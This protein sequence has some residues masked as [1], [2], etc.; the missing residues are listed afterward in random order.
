ML[1]E[2]PLPPLVVTNPTTDAGRRLV[3]L[4][5][6]AQEATRILSSCRRAQRDAQDAVA[7]TE[8]ALRAE[9]DRSAELGEQNAKTEVALVRKIEDSKIAAARDLHEPRIFAATQRQAQ[10]VFEVR[11]HIE[12]NIADLL[13]ELR[14]EAEQ[15][16]ADLAEAREQISPIVQAYSAIAD[17]VRTLTEAVHRGRMAPPQNRFTPSPALNT[18]E[19]W[20][21]PADDASVPMP[22]APTATPL[23]S[24]KTNPPR[25]PHDLG[26]HRADGLIWRWRQA[27]SP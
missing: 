14:P 11:M 8:A 26:Q 22:D 3:E 17:K 6:D 23:R 1:S 18:R 27:R 16:V 5:A 7:V 12:H 20:A 13:D 2:Q 24:S 15:I 4:H 21:L 9:L 19:R 10:A 25:S